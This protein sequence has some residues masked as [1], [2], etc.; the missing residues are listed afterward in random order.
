MLHSIALVTGLASLALTGAL[1]FINLRT[2]PDSWMRGELVA[3]VLLPLLTGFFPLATATGLLGLWSLATGGLGAIALGAA[4]ADLVGLA[5]VVA[6]VLLFRKLVI[7]TNRRA[8]EPSNVIPLA[9][10][11]ETP[12]PVSPRK[13]EGPRR[14]AA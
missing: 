2:R 6:T 12:R 8:A 11:P 10:Q 7:E 5:A 1:F 13:P 14:K 4:G 3:S 9:P